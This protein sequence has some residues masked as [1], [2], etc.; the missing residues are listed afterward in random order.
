MELLLN[1]FIYSNTSTRVLKKDDTKC[2]RRYNKVYKSV[3]KEEVRNIITSIYK[4]L[5]HHAR[6]N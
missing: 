4:H 3:L 2:F 5:I 1:I 6:V